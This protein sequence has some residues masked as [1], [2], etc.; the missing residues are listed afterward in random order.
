MNRFPFELPHSLK[1]HLELFEKDQDK[2][3]YMLE[4][5]LTRRGYD[6]V[7]Y[8]LLGWFYLMQK[9][10]AKAL[11]CA[12]KA[13]SFAPGSPFFMHLPYYF[14]HPSLFDA[15]LPKEFNNSA[16]IP[17]L[18]YNRPEVSGSFFLD[19]DSLIIRLSRRQQAYA[20]NTPPRTP[21]QKKAAQKQQKQGDEDA[22]DRKHYGS[23]AA[24]RTLARIYEQQE[25]Y[26]KAIEV[27]MRLSENSKDKDERQQFEQEINRLKKLK[28]ET[29]E[30]AASANPDDAE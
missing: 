29:N 4:R 17:S 2:A 16:A 14:E 15:W 12:V 27:F 13:R 5:H 24:S 10:R 18:A 7:G 1:S 30:Q 11:E 6:A 25:Y 26:E 22:A 19:I 28:A 9:K 3:I 21:V 8:C 20:N 23:R